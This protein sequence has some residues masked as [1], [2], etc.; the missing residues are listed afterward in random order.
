MKN[1]YLVLLFISFT[2]FAIQF[3]Y[4]ESNEE[5]AVLC[6]YF[7]TLHIIFAIVAYVSISLNKNE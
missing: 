1:F 4:K 3:T 6:L 2:S 5:K 7:I